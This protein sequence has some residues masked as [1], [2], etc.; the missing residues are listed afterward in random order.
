[1]PN[2]HMKQVLTALVFFPL[3]AL[4]AQNTDS[5][6]YYLKKGLEEKEAK[7]YQVA[8]QYFKEAIEQDPTSAVAY[9]ENGYANLE[10][11]R[12]DEAKLNFTRVYELDPTNDN[13]IRELVELNYNYRHY[14][15]AIELAEKCKS[16]PNADR[17][18]ALSYY[19]LEDYPG[20]AKKIQEILQK[21][22]NNAELTYTLAKCNWEMGYEEKAIPYY[23]KAVQLDEN[24]PG[25]FFELGILY[26]NNNRFKEAVAAFSKAA[27]K[28]Y[29]QSNDFNENLGFACLYSGEYDRGEKLLLEIYRRRPGDKDILRDMAQAYYDVK[30]Y[31]KAL[32]FCQQLLE[33][34]KNDA[35]ALYQAGMCF[36]KKGQTQRGQ[37]MCDKAIEMDPSLGKLRQK[38]MTMGL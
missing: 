24:R 5:S 15:K 7:R 29:V 38:K 28:G 6:S 21:D 33:A 9:L 36:Q 17:V 30:M 2:I 25:W 8:S 23:A 26:Y 19:H 35:K 32:E 18:I 22:P 31:D 12:M 10:M 16:C 34:D 4:F 14:Q 3:T 27:D 20:A 1:M 11:R 37:Q 13:A